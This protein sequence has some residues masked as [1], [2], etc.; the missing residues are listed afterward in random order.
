MVHRSLLLHFVGDNGVLAVEKYDTELFDW[1]L[2][3]GDL[4]IVEKRL[5]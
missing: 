3:H 2:A 4:A 5:P 1:R